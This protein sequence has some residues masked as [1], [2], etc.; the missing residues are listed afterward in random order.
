MITIEKLHEELTKQIEA[1]NGNIPVVFG[2]CN[3]LHFATSTGLTF[4]DNLDEYY[5]EEVHPDDR[6]EDDVDNV[7][8]VGE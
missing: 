7:F 8:F 3:H 1:G 5:L 4:V 2:D 6:N